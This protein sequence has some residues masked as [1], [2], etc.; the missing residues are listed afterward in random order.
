MAPWN[1]EMVIC[2][3][4]HTFCYQHATDAFTKEVVIAYVEGMEIDDE[5]RDAIINYLQ[6]MDADTYAEC[7]KCAKSTMFTD[8]RDENILDAIG[9]SIDLREI[10]EC[11]PS[12]FCPICTLTSI[13]AADAFRYLCAMNNVTENDVGAEIRRK[14]SSYTE[15]VQQL[16]EIETRNYVRRCE[17]QSIASN[18]PQ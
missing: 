14:F 9:V 15:M 5:K 17:Q 8:E 18:T 4:G 12:K 2:E 3:Q 11:F 1:A 13:P 7:T 16:T 10:E 6:T